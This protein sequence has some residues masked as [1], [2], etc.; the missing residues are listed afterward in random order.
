M[1]QLA[2]AIGLQWWPASG[3]LMPPRLAP[4]LR[5]SVLFQ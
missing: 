2:D 1:S 5:P 4:A 3:V